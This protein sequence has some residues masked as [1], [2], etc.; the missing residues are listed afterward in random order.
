[1]PKC[2]LCNE[3]AESQSVRAS[4]VFGGTQEHAFWQCEKCEA[5][6]LNPPLG[7]AD[8][9]K[10]YLKEFEKFMSTRVGD[11]RDWTSAENHKTTNQDQVKRRMPFVK[12]YLNEGIDLLEVG[13]S[14]GFMLDAFR[15]QGAKCV[16]VEPS[17]EFGEFLALSGHEYVDD[18]AKLGDKKFD[19][20]TH[21]FVFEHIANPFD[22]LTKMHAL[23]KKGGVM[24][25]EIPCANDP[26]T[27]VYNIEAFEKFYWSIAHHYYYTPASL[28]YVME[29]LGYQYELLPEQRYDLSN[30]MVWMNEGR[31]GGQ[32]QFKEQLGDAVNNTYTQHLKDTWQC[33][34]MFLYM[35]KS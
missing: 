12:K 7:E 15:E 33:D 19:V 24:V 6:Y 26:L 17:G 3:S 31:P 4:Y 20:I 11:H 22:F 32:G 10:F 25:A 28:K 35:W 23:L 14:S 29:K 8:E 16:G 9:K 18:V 30:H 34:T 5:I 27:S 13:C 21:F 1:M 2:R